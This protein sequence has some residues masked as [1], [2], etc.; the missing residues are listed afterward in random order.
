M[1]T[2]A[3]GAESEYA[4]HHIL[5]AL[6]VGKAQKVLLTREKFSGH[7]FVEPRFQLD[8]NVMLEDVVNVLQDLSLSGYLSKSE[9]VS[10]YCVK[11]FTQNLLLVGRCPSCGSTQ[12][13]RGSELEHTCGYSGFETMFV[14]KRGMVCPACGGSLGKEGTDYRSKG[15]VYRCISCS[16]LF[17]NYKASYEC[18]NCGASYEKGNEPSLEVTSYEVT[19]KFWAGS[20]GLLAAYRL[21]DTIMMKLQQTG[22]KVT[23]PFYHQTR[24]GNIFLDVLAENKSDRIGVKIYPLSL[25]EESVLLDDLLS[26]KS[27]A[28]LKKGIVILQSNLSSAATA[29]LAKS[30]ITLIKPDLRS[31]QVLE[32]LIAVNRNEY[33][34]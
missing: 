26:Y 6:A 30:G 21:K 16:K 14:S 12:I 22:Y 32:E 23:A 17:P 33:S 13:R 7:I 2:I 11:C 10:T 5:T 19:E 8:E 18:S 3:R 9:S 20:L 15:K 28:K 24:S 29:R 27:L 4:M 31:A 1:F 34:R 25:P